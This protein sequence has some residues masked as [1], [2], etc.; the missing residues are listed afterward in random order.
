MV[1][2]FSVPGNDLSG[3]IIG[4]LVVGFYNHFC[5]C[6]QSSTLGLFNS[7]FVLIRNN[8]MHT[9]HCSSIILVAYFYSFCNLL[10]DDLFLCDLSI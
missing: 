3:F 7:S 6:A 2:A 9:C 10:A 8:A 5:W 4:L 1:I